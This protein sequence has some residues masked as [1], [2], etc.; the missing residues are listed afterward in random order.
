MEEEDLRPMK[1]AWR[2]GDEAEA[3]RLIPEA[4]VE[5]LTVTGTPDHALGRVDEYRKAGITLPI[6][7]PIGDVDY[8]VNELAPG[9]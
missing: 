5:A 3:R 2:S 1:E 6:L 4:A 7:M 8:A 9:G